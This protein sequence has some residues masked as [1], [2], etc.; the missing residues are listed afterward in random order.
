MFQNIGGVGFSS[1]SDAYRAG[2]ETAES[3]L[4][5]M[6][7]E[8]PDLVILFSTIQYMNFGGFN[9]LLEG[10]YS[11]FD[12]DTQLLGGTTAG[13]II[14]QGCF[15]KGVAAMGLLSK[16]KFDFAISFAKNIK[17]D[18]ELVAEKCAEEIAKKL[19]SSKFKN[20]F[21]LNLP[22]GTTTPK[23]PFFSD[24]IRVI[25]SK[26]FSRLILLGAELSLFFFQKGP[27]REEIIIE[28]LAKKL[29]NFQMIGGSFI[30]DN[31]GFYNFQF[32]NKK[33]YTN[34]LI[35]LGIATNLGINVNSNFGLFEKSEKFKITRKSMYDLVIEEINGKNAFNEILRILRWPSYFIEDSA[36]ILRRTFYAPIGYRLNGEL[37]TSIMAFIYGNGI[38]VSP[39][40][41]CEEACI[42]TASGYQLINVVDENLK[43]TVNKK[44]EFGLITSCIVRLETLGRNV[45]K[46]H[47]KLINH[48]KGKPFIQMYAVG[49]DV[50][51]N[52]HKPKRIANSYN[53]AIF[54]L[55]GEE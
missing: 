36:R 24:N 20:K 42:M 52:K 48:F 53:T 17:R 13:F 26:F 8:K 21:L 38:V 14:P 29:P 3:L 55:E 12:K 22:S 50:F 40:V 9:K 31:K 35:T 10:F 46:V 41:R 34:V 44:V 33:V 6:N 4:S 43:D 11:R 19:S 2:I 16:G 30:D 54:Y 1:K 47:D 5:S 45:Y 37:Y 39:K 49:E 7:G 51:S 27:G 18:P 32:V 28:T 25:K 23:I 15:T